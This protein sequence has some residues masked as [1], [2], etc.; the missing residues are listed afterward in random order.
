M[1]LKKIET[2]KGLRVVIYIR[3]S[4]P[5]QAEE[6]IPLAAQIWEC[7]EYASAEAGR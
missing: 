6:E 3:V 1:V 2:E 4:T 7:R 5:G